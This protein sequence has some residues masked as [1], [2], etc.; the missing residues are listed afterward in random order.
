MLRRCVLFLFFTCK[1][2]GFML[3]KVK[4]TRSLSPRY[5]EEP[6]KIIQDI[7]FRAPL[8]DSWSFLELST[9][10]KNHMINSASLITNHE[11]VVGVYSI[12]K[13]LVNNQVD[14]L[15]IH[16]T[17][18]IPS[19]V[20][21]TITALNNANV[22]YDILEIS[23]YN[24]LDSI[25]FIFQ[26]VGLY[27]LSGLVF[28][29]FARFFT[30][31]QPGGGGGRNNFM[32]PL[33]MMMSNTQEV[34]ILSLN[35]TFNDVAGC[36][37]AKFELVEVVDFLKKPEKYIAAGAK[38]PKGVLLEGPPGTGKTLLARAVAGEAGVP[39]FE[40]SGSQ[41][42]EMFV[43][44][45]ASRVRDLF[46]KAN[47]NSPCVVFIDEI[48]AVGRQ[49]GAGFA[50]GN[51]EREQTLNQILTNMDGFS[52]STGVIVLAATN[53]ADILD[54]A[55][56]RPGRFDRKIM[57]GLPDRDGRREIMDVH[58][59]DKKI[60]TPKY[61]DTLSSLTEGFSGADIA[62]LANEAA[63]LSVRY[64]ET[65]ITSDII[66]RAFEKM[67]IGL[68]KNVET[69]P[70]EVLKLVA[71]HEV[72]HAL[73]AMLFNDMFNVQKITIQSNKNGA[74]GYTLFT[75]KEKFANFPTKK[76][77]LANMIIALGG[78]AA[79]VAYYKNNLKI[80]DN[81]DENRLFHDISDLEITT[82]ASND[83]KQANSIARK[84][85]S[86]FGL[87]QQIGLYDSND[88][89]QPFLGKELAS[90]GSKISDYTREEIDKEIKELVDFCY[91]ASL[92]I[93]EKNK[94]IFHIIT[95]ELLDKK[96]LS[97]IDIEKYRVSY[98]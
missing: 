37:E 89:S 8:G 17:R 88:Q 22:K 35:V 34:D 76:Y 26:L 3:P 33:G 7:G 42:I 1:I 56:T 81:Y 83:L 82:G 57:V 72:G 78:R 20:D 73:S 80:Q 71:Y 4:S 19:L 63:I 79:E 68:P 2:E 55:L 29:A 40:A 52:Q 96:T 53:R 24:P 16:A 11:Q 12:D 47:E 60:S 44:V 65:E 21:S 50:G 43:G 5:V 30:N 45:G 32:N 48:D 14:S 10:A 27:I 95:Q 92:N 69:R 28:G 6:S 36:E 77:M 97:T 15:N 91:K 31:G 18:L 59:K 38:I 9:N 58:F 70:E 98:Y 49:R 87:G 23:R 51:D 84:Y 64:N 90:G 93:I 25:P 67:T 85:V 74:G 13:N 66:Y 75:P 94:N 62:N 41:F 86:L 46:N 61:L 54:S 39:F